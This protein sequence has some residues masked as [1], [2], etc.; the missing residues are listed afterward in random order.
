MIGIARSQRTP[1]VEELYANG[2]NIEDACSQ[3]LGSGHHEDDHHD[4][5]DNN[6]V[7][8]AATNLIEIGNANLDVET[9]NNLELGYRRH[10][11]I[12]GRNSL[13][14]MFYVLGEWNFLQQ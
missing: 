10:V 14:D 8:H 1:Q 7:L 2:A 13:Y 4:D 11:L 6:L 5:H 12:S 3:G 9:S